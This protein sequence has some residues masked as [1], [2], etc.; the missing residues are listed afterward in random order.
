MRRLRTYTDRHLPFT[1]PLPYTISLHSFDKLSIF[2]T[3]NHIF[4]F[5]Q[6]INLR[7]PKSSSRPSSLSP[8]PPWPP[9][10]SLSECPSISGHFQHTD[11]ISRTVTVY[12]CPTTMSSSAGVAPASIASTGVVT[13]PTAAGS[14]IAYATGAASMKGVSAL[15]AVVAGGVALV[16]ALR[17]LKPGIP[18]NA[19]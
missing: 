17:I 10:K 5:Q 6:T 1:F 7:Q 3:Q 15:A 4:P 8:S 18:L 13:A 14:P 9:P 12:A 19:D 16:R 2:Q 11:D